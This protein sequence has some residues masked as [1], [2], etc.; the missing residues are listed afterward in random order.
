M[1]NLKSAM[2]QQAFDF[3][4]SRVSTPNT[5]G[6]LYPPLA[7]MHP[8]KVQRS[9]ADQPD[10]GLQLGFADP[11]VMTK[12]SFATPNVGHLPETPSKFG[13]GVPR[14]TSPAFKFSRPD[15]ELGPE[16][17]KMMQEL[18]Q[19]AATIKAK[20]IEERAKEEGQDDITKSPLVTPGRKMAVPKGKKSRFSDAHMEQFKKMDS[21]AGHPSAFRIQP[22]KLETAKTSLKRSKSQAKLDDSESGPSRSKA[23]RVEPT[24]AGGPKQNHKS[25]TPGKEFVNPG[26]VGKSGRP[27][28]RDGPSLV[29]YGIAAVESGKGRFRSNIMTPTKASLARAESLRHPKS[30]MGG[31]NR[32]T[33]SRNSKPVSSRSENNHKY[34]S[35]LTSFGKMKSLMRRPGEKAPNPVAPLDTESITSPIPAPTL[36]PRTLNDLN[37]QPVS[38]P[39]TPK[40]AIP[41][42][43]SA[44][45][46]NYTPTKIV[47]VHSSMTP[48]PV[49]G[50]ALPSPSKTDEDPVVYPSIPQLSSS[51]L[52]LGTP[53]PLLTPRPRKARP[54]GPGD[55]SFRSASSIKFGVAPNATT[56]RQ[57]RPSFA[58]STLEKLPAYAH[59]MSNKKRHRDDSSEEELQDERSPKKLRN[60]ILPKPNLQTPSKEHQTSKL[61]SPLKRGAS[62]IGK[63]RMLTMSRLNRLASPKKR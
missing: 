60:S 34:L 47:K 33:S 37:R 12:Q 21:I 27:A 32:S 49:K 26:I 48:S 52:P 22:G 36:A 57:V 50:A 42:S 25:S 3:S 41:Q 51:P 11:V 18:R 5:A 45:K 63:G 2:S 54:S 9:T 43:K 58:P 39:G 1:A 31:L 8:S 15:A 28:S 53:R 56:I 13:V 16:A 24:V 62:V 10:S 40:S 6:R 55:F 29:P 23:V 44:K 46:L 19:E 35:S 30:L 61:P 17:Q 4:S 7:E 38:I 14:N 20:M 59:G